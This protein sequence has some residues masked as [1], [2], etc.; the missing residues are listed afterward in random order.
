MFL[1]AF[2]KLLVLILD[3]GSQSLH[4]LPQ[5]FQFFSLGLLKF[6]H[7]PGSSPVATSS[8]LIH[9]FP[10]LPSLLL[11]LLHSLD[12]VLTPHVVVQGVP[13]W[14]IDQA[15]IATEALNFG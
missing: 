13:A 15:E 3:L 12:M 10:L 11:Q 7:F 9:N 5:L 4:S 6:G 14:H 2:G 1:P 8:L